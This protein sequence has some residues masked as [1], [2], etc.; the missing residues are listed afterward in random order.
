M[1][2]KSDNNDTKKREDEIEAGKELLKAITTAWSYY[3]RQV[4]GFFA[5]ENKQETNYVYNDQTV[6]Q[7]KDRIR[8]MMVE[9]QDAKYHWA[10]FTREAL[11]DWEKE[12]KE[13]SEDECFTNVLNTILLNQ[14]R[15]LQS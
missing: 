6:Q 9:L 8:K 12:K 15:K 3:F 5:S 14:I 4:K 10:N 7:A 11:E 1:E 2:F 13:L